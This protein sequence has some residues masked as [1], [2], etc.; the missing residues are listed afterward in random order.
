VL[1][2]VAAH[3]VWIHQTLLKSLIKLAEDNGVRKDLI[4]NI[5]QQ[6]GISTN[7]STRNPMFYSD[8]LAGRVTVDL[9]LRI[10]PKNDIH[11]VANKTF[12]FSSG[13]IRHLLNNG[14]KV[15]MDY[16]KTSTN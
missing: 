11:T 14:Y 16:I 3:L 12:D 10:D 6:Q 2:V 1:V 8:L 9:I 7:L 15:T 5:L 13:T 4:D